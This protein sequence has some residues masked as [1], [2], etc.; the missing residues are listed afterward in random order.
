MQN[1]V[2]ISNDN[3]QLF[4]YYHIW[5]ATFTKNAVFFHHW[6]LVWAHQTYSCPIHPCKKVG[7]GPNVLKT[8]AYSFPTFLFFDKDILGNEADME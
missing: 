8:S 7:K 3:F 2:V 1:T 4:D 5:R 6:N